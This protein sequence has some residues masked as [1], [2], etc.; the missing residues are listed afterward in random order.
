MSHVAT[1]FSRGRRPKEGLTHVH[2][3]KR[4]VVIRSSYISDI[5]AVSKLQIL[6][7]GF[8][9]QN[10]RTQG[11]IDTSDWRFDSGLFRYCQLY[12]L[13]KVGERATTD[14]L[15]NKTNI[16]NGLP[17]KSRL[18]QSHV[19]LDQWRL[20]QIQDSHSIDS[21]NSRSQVDHLVA[22]KAYMSCP[23]R[24]DPK[25]SNPHQLDTPGALA[26]STETSQ[27]SW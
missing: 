4:R 15:C 26:P 17:R 18:R 3:V 19:L 22:R 24:H 12:A 6:F 16:Q 7:Q 11:S 25:H 21:S 10:A 27:S 5:A 23:S 9:S 2:K 1:L 20:Q 14:V 13:R 8:A